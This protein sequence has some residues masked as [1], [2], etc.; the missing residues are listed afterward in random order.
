M[1]PEL[2][3]D[4]CYCGTDAGAPAR[5]RASE[6]TRAGL[7]SPLSRADAA[8]LR[9]LLLPQI[10]HALSD[11]DGTDCLSRHDLDGVAIAL[12]DLEVVE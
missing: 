9:Q 7:L 2:H 4:C 5:A 1:E 12:R 8:E 11:K 10:A 6:L 3:E